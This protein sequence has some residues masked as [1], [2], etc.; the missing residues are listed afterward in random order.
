MIDNTINK[1]LII[2]LGFISLAIILFLIEL[3]I[4]ASS[5]HKIN[6]DPSYYNYTTPCLIVSYLIMGIFIFIWTL[7]GL[8][9]LWSE[10]I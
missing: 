9:Y 4:Q 2:T 5:K 3:I 1:F 8:I 6:L 7:L 10:I